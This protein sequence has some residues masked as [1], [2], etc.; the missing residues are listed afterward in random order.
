MAAAAA[1][2]PSEPDFDA[3]LPAGPMERGRI[4]P[5][6]RV[7]ERDRPFMSQPAVWVPAAAVLVL[8]LGVGAWALLKKPARVETPATAAGPQPPGPRALPTA[9]ASP[10]QATGTRPPLTE[11]DI[12]A[13][14]VAAG[15]QSTQPPQATGWTDRETELPLTELQKLRGVAGWQGNKLV[16]TL[17]NGSGWRVTEIFVMTSRWVDDQFVD[18][19]RANRLLPVQAQIDDSVGDLLK[20]V[21][22]DRRKPGVNPLDAGPFEVDAGPQPEAYKWKIQAARGYPPRTAP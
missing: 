22:P 16:V 19:E 2:R 4:S 17:Y 12:P 18:A 6:V 13:V 7:A 3:T 10:R 11:T 9:Q 5:V 8:A 20:K 21:A 15:T 1:A 14:E